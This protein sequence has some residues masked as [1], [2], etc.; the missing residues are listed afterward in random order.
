MSTGTP[1]HLG[2]AAG[3]AAAALLAIAAPCRAQAAARDSAATRIPVAYDSAATLIPVATR[4][5]AR[6]ESLVAGDIA[7]RAPRPADRAPDSSVVTPVGWVTRRVL[8]AGEPLLEPAVEPPPAVRSGQ[9]VQLTYRSGDIRLTMP[10][11]AM[12]S[13][14]VGEEVTVR[15]DA[16]RRLRAIVTAPGRVS[17]R[18]PRSRS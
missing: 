16:S 9:T 18:E 15:L 6:G 17:A 4:A 14:L 5:I 12:S 2:L 10:G 8:R 1:R 3:A 7:W 11:V 13:A